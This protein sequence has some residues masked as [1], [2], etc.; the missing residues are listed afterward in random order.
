MK[1]NRTTPAGKV[2]PRRRHQWEGGTLIHFVW[3]VALNR[4]CSCRFNSE[5]I[6]FIFRS[7]AR[8][9]KPSWV[10]RYPKYC[11]HGLGWRRERER[12]GGGE[13]KKAGTLRAA[14]EEWVGSGIPKVEG[15]GR[16]WGNFATLHNI[17]R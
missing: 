4:L 2:V 5:C 6:L 10:T 8:F 14:G 12:G 1:L 17:L 3:A 7:G 15:T 13:G 9:T 11:P 16:N